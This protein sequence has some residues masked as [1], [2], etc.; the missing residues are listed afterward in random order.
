NHPYYEWFPDGKI[1]IT[2]NIFD[3]HP[4]RKNK[5][6]LIWESEIGESKILTYDQLYKQVMSLANSLLEIGIKKGDVVTIY[7][8]MIPEAMVSMLAC[9]RIGAIHNVVFG[10]FG[11]QALRERIVSSNSKLI[12]TSDVG[13]RRGKEINYIENVIK[14][15]EGLNV[16]VIILN[17]ADKRSKN[18]YDF[19]DLI[20]RNKKVEAER[21]ESTHPLFILYTSGT[22]GK[23][24]GVVHATG[25]YTVW[26]YFHVKW[27]FN[28][29]NDDIFFSLPDIGWIN[30]HSYST[31]GP[32]LNGATLLWYEGAPDYPDPEIWWRLVEKYSVTYMWV[33]PTAV[34]LLMKYYEKVNYDISSLK[35]IVSAGE[36]LGIEPWK[37]LV[38]LTNQETYIIETW[39]QT[40]NSG[41]ITSPGGF[42]INGIYYKLGS[43]GHPLPGIEVTIVDDNGRE[44]PPNE[45]GY[46]VIKRSAPAFMISLWNDD[47]RYREYFSKYGVYFTGD[48][49]YIDE[50][51]YVYVL[52]RVD[53]V[54]KIAGHRLSPAEIENI[55]LENNKV[56][57]AAVIGVPDVEKGNA[58]VAFVVL[59]KDY[60]PSEDLKN[61]IIRSIREKLG[62]IAVIRNVFFLERL[63]K[64]RTGK[65]M[66]RVLRA[67]LTNNVLG[68]LSTLEE[69]EALEELRKVLLK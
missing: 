24:K 4:E 58:L 65:I 26:A 52:G 67:V 22:T 20:K 41:F 59:K 19:K 15:I 44:L 61:E 69:V 18:F 54:V 13:Y 17:R 8:P 45:K 35:M 33:A 9:A 30:G 2:Y 57:E 16:N 31:Y 40:E 28:F 1:N 42:F 25:A 37:W 6:A 51:G 43:V 3:A 14:A 39:G 29:Q 11:Y 21:V 68:D 12:I 5:A 48:Y 53:D 66:R 36:I 38:N 23:P 7:M 56:A 55:I 49:G 46:I 50:E 34:R 47:E 27:L 62:P 60:K 63:P 64:T 10:G 32:L